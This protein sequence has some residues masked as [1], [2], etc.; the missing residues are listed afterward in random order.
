MQPDRDQIEM[1]V[2]GL[3][4]HAGS[5]GF[6]SLRAFYEED[7]G[8]AFRINPTGLS[9]GLPFLIEVAEDDAGRAANDP[10]PVVFCPP[11][12]VFAD[13]ERAREVDILEGLALSVECDARPSQARAMLE[14][15]LGP[16]T[17]VVRSGGKWTD[18]VTGE[19]QDKL[20]LHWRLRI[21]A[22]GEDLPALKRAR[23]IAARL[24]GGDPSNKPVCHPIRWPGS[25][26]RKGDPVLCE[27][28]TAHPDC[29]IDLDI[30]LAALTAA[31]PAEPPP[32]QKANGKDHSD[33]GADWE[34]HVANVL[35]GDSFHGALVPLAAKLLTAGM[36]DG[37]AVNLLRAI[38]KSSTG[39]HDGRWEARYAD[40]PRAVSTAGEK[41]GKADEPKAPDDDTDVWDGGD[42]PGV[43]RPRG[44]LSATQF[45]R[46]FLSLLIA[47]GGTGKTALRYLQAIELARETTET[48]TGFKKFQRC[49]VLIIGLEDG[50]DEMDR[51]I[52]AA[53]IHHRIKRAEIKEHLFCWSPKGMKLAEMKGNSRQIG[54]LERRLRGKIER[55]GIDLVLVDPLIKAHGLEENSNEAMDFVCELLTKLTIEYNIAIDTS[56][57]T[58]K[59][60]LVAG[61]ADNARGASATRDAGRLGYT[62][63]TMTDEEAATFGIEPGQRRFYVRL[64]K[65]KVN[66]EPPAEKATWFKLVGVR[67]GN[68]NEMY[69]NGDEVQTVEPWTPPDTWANLSNTALNAALTEIDAGMSNGQRYSG[70]PNAKERAAWPVVQRHCPD[71]TEAQCR[72]IVRTWLKTGLLFAKEYDDPVDRKKRDGLCVNTAKR[73]S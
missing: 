36:H 7:S 16:A 22:R 15:I 65:A 60:T 32:R 50:R 66:I 18:P 12:A 24:V 71:K 20:H 53:L 28:D 64:D 56:Q 40:I 63:S 72:E 45:C 29:E 23:D 11:I 10:K 59:G 57:H 19:V 51:R 35:S 21:P 17:I 62:L 68:G 3:F 44:W 43:I 47:P 37:A 58:R 49:K 1:F 4:R 46:Q 61:D 31:S 14:A 9:G 52:Q 6:V 30:A 73:P 33:E 39:A 41:F 42:D 34:T 25:W 27:I 38:M 54:E 55:L 69:P 5:K 48:I 67:L 26:H 8:K 13:K 70:A 2:D